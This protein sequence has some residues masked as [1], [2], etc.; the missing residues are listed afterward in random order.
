MILPN[1]FVTHT[2]VPSNQKLNNIL[3]CISR[4]ISA[5][6]DFHSKLGTRNLIPDSIS[7]ASTWKILWQ[8][9]RNC[10]FPSLSHGNDDI[11]SPTSKLPFKDTVPLIKERN[12]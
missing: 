12:N 9:V 10:D 6:I 1:T 7:K 2:C 8:L 3:L 11:M 4:I 5:F